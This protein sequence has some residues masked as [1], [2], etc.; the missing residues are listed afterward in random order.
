MAYDCY[1]LQLCLILIIRIICHC[2]NTHTKVMNVYKTSCFTKI[3]STRSHNPKIRKDDSN[4]D[5]HHSLLEQRSFWR[6]IIMNYFH[7]ISLIRC[8]IWYDRLQMFSHT[9]IE[10]LRSRYKHLRKF[11]INMFCE[12]LAIGKHFKENFFR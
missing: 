8:M 11:V 3:K 7:L 5:S 2:I 10:H 9:H 1:K 12:N 6:M 4:A